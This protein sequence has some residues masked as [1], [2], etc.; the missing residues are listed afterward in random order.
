[1]PE[2]LPTEGGAI[3]LKLVD[4]RTFT[5]P[6]PAGT[7]VGTMIRVPLPALF[8]P[9][10]PGELPEATATPVDEH[11]PVAEAFS[12][13]NRGLG[14]EPVAM[15]VASAAGGWKDESTGGGAEDEDDPEGEADPRAP[16]RYEAGDTAG[17]ME[18]SGDTDPRSAKRYLEMVDGNVEAAVGLYRQM[19]SLN[20][21]GE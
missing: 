20:E 3:G 9:A 4:G 15:A 7:P 21:D 6:V 2:G 13:R 19:S 12:R 11:P 1:M 8:N 5:V 18:A 10:P 14:S 16:S 17:F